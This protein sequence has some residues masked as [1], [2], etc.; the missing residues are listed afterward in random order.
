MTETQRVEY[1]VYLCLGRTQ[2][3]SVNKRDHNDDNIYYG[4][5]H[6]GVHCDHDYVVGRREGIECG[7]GVEWSRDRPSQLS[8]VGRGVAAFHSMLRTPLSPLAS[9]S[10]PLVLVL[11]SRDVLRFEEWSGL[12]L[13]R[14][15]DH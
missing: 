6:Y 7:R 12:Q 5:Y 3:S 1:Y 10:S 9:V 13:L 8:S 11:W 14:L 4:E 2:T 15:G